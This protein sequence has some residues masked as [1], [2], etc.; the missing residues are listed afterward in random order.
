[1]D[2]KLKILRQFSKFGV[3][4]RDEVKNYLGEVE[5]LVAKGLVQKTY[6]K[7]KVFY[8]LTPKAIP[9][10]ELE[11]T[12]ILAEVKM[13]AQITRPS[14]VYNRFLEDIRLLNEKDK[15][16]ADFIF[17]SDWQLKDPVVPSQLELSKY[18]YLK[19]RRLL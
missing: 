16:A 13:A 8:E 4:H 11:R 10:L 18:R 6:R 1:M 3:L 14:S 15:K 19:S 12:A 9:I 5:K 7:G 2:I 17:L